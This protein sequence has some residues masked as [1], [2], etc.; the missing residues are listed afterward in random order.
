MSSTNKTT[1]YELSQFI[2][3]DKPAW[4]AD[5]NADMAKIDAQMKL[6]D[7]SATLANTTNTTQQTAIETN[8]GNITTLQTNVG[9]L[10]T[11]VNTA[12]TNIANLTKMMNF[13]TNTAITGSDI[14]ITTSGA[15]GKGGTV[16]LNT[17]IDASAFRLG[18][19][20]YF[21]N[22][23][24]TEDR[25]ITLEAISGLSGKYGIKINANPLS[26]LPNEAYE[27]S[28]GCMINIGNSTAGNSIFT[29][30]QSIAVSDDGYI[31]IAVSTNST[32][33]IAK[34]TRRD[35]LFTPFTIYNTSFGDTPA[36]NNA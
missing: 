31:Y 18:G 36:P 11:A 32:Y 28:G 16:N 6:N 14:V 2:Q 13:T 7:D 34:A 27:I 22:N 4:L 15:I 19:S 30:S 12:N 21:V 3:T 20:L 33:T 26:T 9:T 29:S 23:S 8:A 35:F 10:S 1:N 5:Y 24:S 17:N 25:S